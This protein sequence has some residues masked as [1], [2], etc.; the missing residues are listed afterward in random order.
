MANKTAPYVQNTPNCNREQWLRFWRHFRTLRQTMNLPQVV[1]RIAY[2]YGHDAAAFLCKVLNGWHRT[3]IVGPH[4]HGSLLACGI[5]VKG[6]SHA[7]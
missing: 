4:T 7:E 2:L 3:S 1:A 5:C 6:A